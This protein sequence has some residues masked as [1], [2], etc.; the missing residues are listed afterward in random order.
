MIIAQ[1]ASCGLSLS[2]AQHEP[3]PIHIKFKQ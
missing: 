2:A 3:K 1:L